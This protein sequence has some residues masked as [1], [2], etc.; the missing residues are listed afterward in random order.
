MSHGR[1]ILRGWKIVGEVR[2]SAYERGMS[3]VQFIY[4]ALER[5]LGNRPEQPRPRP[6]S[7]GTARSG[8]P[9]GISGQ[10]DELYK[11]EP[12]RPNLS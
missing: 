3:A 6:R 12:W 10:V 11:P 9:G 1:E 2:R 4:E 7:I 5:E 8:V